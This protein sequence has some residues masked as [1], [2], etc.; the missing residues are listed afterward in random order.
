[1]RGKRQAAP[2]SA[3]V[4]VVINSGGSGSRGRGA[5]PQSPLGRLLR[6]DW[7]G[8]SESRGPDVVQLGGHAHQL[9]ASDAADICAI[10][11]GVA[12]A[13]MI[14][15]SFVGVVTARDHLAVAVLDARHVHGQHAHRR[16]AHGVG[17]SQPK[18]DRGDGHGDGNQNGEDGSVH[19]KPS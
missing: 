16:L 18:P 6:I 10:G 17:R 1:M 15:A 12:A 14:L 3:V 8:Q 5:R 19:T 7:F 9:A 11:L 13:G 4:A 2:T